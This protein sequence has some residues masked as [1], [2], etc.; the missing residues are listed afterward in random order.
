MKRQQIAMRTASWN[1]E[2][3]EDQH[4]YA[5]ERGTYGLFGSISANGCGSIAVHNICCL[6][7]KPM[8]YRT[9]WEH[10]NKRL[11]RTV[12]F[13]ILGTTPLSIAPYLKQ[14]GFSVAR[15]KDLSAIPPH[16]A[17]IMLYA[18]KKPHLGAHYIAVSQES[19]HCRIHNGTCRIE[20]FPK[21]TC[22]DLP[23]LIDHYKTAKGAF[24]IV[25]WGIDRQ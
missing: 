24:G 20:G 7:K 10:F 11:R 21:N 22:V 2:L 23:A 19:G 12:L 1:A 25:V 18:Y 13:G 15:C 8:P 14:Q 4:L 17:Y 9:A 6:L 16:D 3:I 5:K